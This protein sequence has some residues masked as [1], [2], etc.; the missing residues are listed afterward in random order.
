MEIYIS[1]KPNITYLFLKLI[2]ASN[3]EQI[4]SNETTTIIEQNSDAEKIYQAIYKTE[5]QKTTFDLGKD[6]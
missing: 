6:F 5:S 4:T 1:S 3:S 2:R